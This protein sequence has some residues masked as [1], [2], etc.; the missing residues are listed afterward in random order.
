MRISLLALVLT[1]ASLEAQTF[2][3]PGA[4]WTYTYAVDNLIDPFPPVYSSY[5]I[6]V[7]GD[8]LLLGHLCSE[9]QGAGLAC[10]ENQGFVYQSGDS[11]YYWDELA[12]SF[13][14]LYRWD[15]T[16]GDT[17]QVHHTGPGGTDTLTYTVTGNGT[18]LVN[19]QLRR[20]LDVQLWDQLGFAFTG[21]Q[22][23]EGIG[24]TG[25]LF[26]WYTALCGGFTMGPLR[27]YVDAGLGL[28][29]APGITQ[30]EIPAATV[31]FAPV[32]AQW[33]Y[34]QTAVFAPPFD[35]TLFI[36]VCTGDTVIQGRDCSII[37]QIAGWPTCMGYERYLSVSGDSVLMWNTALN[38]FTPLHVFN[39]PV[40]SSWQ[41]LIPDPAFPP[42]S[43]TIAWTVTATGST[44]IDGQTL[45]T[46]ELL[47]SIG[48]PDGWVPTG[49]TVVERLGDMA[50]LFPWIYG[51]CDGDVIAPLRCYED[52]DISWLN[53]LFAQ[54]DLSTGMPEVG[55]PGPLLLTPSV[56]P[57]GES[58]SV[59][60]PGA[61]ALE[62]MDAHGRLIAASAPIS[63]RVELR[64][65]APGV[66]TLR[67]WDGT[68]WSFGRA[69]AY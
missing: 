39:A 58:M 32:G 59:T 18:I 64:L 56:A 23:I 67:T 19:S 27:C 50:Y 43:D 57:V 9:V 21:G 42:Q 16:T 68:R 49:G 53:P 47:P 14:L 52:P 37:E 40:G 51:V 1:T 8:T 10:H 6:T 17:W 36:L 69:L 26:P 41:T 65:P 22:L 60:C 61:I 35:S 62:V 38:G 63:G 3:P 31:V 12:A 33:T 34:T 54:C 46:M 48:I 13:S 5:P 7:V 11:V 15:A 24:D 44:V 45:Q 28:Y 29:M 55:S 66:Y 30:C 25:Y 4:T 2:A 20:T